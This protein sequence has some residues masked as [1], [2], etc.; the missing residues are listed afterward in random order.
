MLY[1]INRC[2][3]YLYSYLPYDFTE[4]KSCFD[5]VLGLMWIFKLS[6]VWM[7]FL[8]PTPL[9]EIH[10]HFTQRKVI[11]RIQRLLFNDNGYMKSDHEKN[12]SRKSFMSYVKFDGKTLPS[13]AGVKH[14]NV[15]R[16]VASQVPVL[17]GENSFPGEMVL[18]Q[19][20]RFTGI[21]Y[22]R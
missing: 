7:C 9:T 21:I 20:I 6:I 4:F 16:G 22:G 14:Y 10:Q 12:T 18:P 13:A 19:Y 8:Q 15:S 5:A 1:P 11:Q 17:L 2:M 3:P